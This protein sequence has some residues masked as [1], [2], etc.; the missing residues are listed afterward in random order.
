MPVMERLLVEEVKVLPKGSTPF[1]I[2][3]QDHQCNVSQPCRGGAPV[4]LTLPLRRAGPWAPH[5]LRKR[6]CF[7]RGHISHVML[8]FTL[9]LPCVYN[10]LQGRKYWNWI[11]K[12]MQN[13]RKTGFL[14]DILGPRVIVLLQG[15]LICGFP[16]PPQFSDFVDII[17]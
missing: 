13:W 14:A 7:L 11:R 5:V 3:C 2:Q 4:S 8:C 16:P 15:N 6:G 17:R 10:E 1:C 9:L 12:K